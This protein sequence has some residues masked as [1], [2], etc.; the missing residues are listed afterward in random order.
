M[1]TTTLATNTLSTS[2][3]IGLI[4]IIMAITVGLIITDLVIWPAIRALFQQAFSN[5]PANNPA[6]VI[7]SNTTGFW[8]QITTPVLTDYDRSKIA[9]RAIAIMDEQAKS[10][11]IETIKSES[12][13]PS[14]APKNPFY[15]RVMKKVSEKQKQSDTIKSE[16]Y[17]CEKCD[18]E[19]STVNARN[20]HMKRHR[21]MR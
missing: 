6:P 21:G 7:A 9:R 20:G 1:N 2:G 17:P 15:S 10:E 8:S 19:F 4:L 18:K 11:T 12:L 3:T 14:N 13:L 5:K 16:K